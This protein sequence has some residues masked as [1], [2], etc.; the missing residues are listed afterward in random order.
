M[1]AIGAVGL[2]LMVGISLAVS[3]TFEDLL[4]EQQKAAEDLLGEGD[5]EE[6]DLSNG[7]DLESEIVPLD[8]FLAKRGEPV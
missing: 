1:G 4:E 5:S 6:D 8:E 2:L 7:Y 3:S